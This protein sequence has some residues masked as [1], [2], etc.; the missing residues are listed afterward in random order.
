ME[1]KI[2][3]CDNG[4]ASV[5]IAPASIEIKANFNMLDGLSEEGRKNLR[6][7]FATFFAEYCELIGRVDVYF[8]G[9]SIE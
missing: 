2:L 3:I 5:G 4:D 1:S 6:K 8:D 7:D 9:E